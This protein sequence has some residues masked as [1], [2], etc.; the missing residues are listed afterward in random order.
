MMCDLIVA[1]DNAKFGQPEINLG[2]VLLK[3]V[4]IISRRCQILSVYSST[5]C[6]RLIPS[7]S[8]SSVVCSHGK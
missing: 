5:A 7:S 1:S 6:C 4:L 8:S 2:K 3:E